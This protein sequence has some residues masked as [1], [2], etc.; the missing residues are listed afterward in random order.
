M[1]KNIHDFV[2][3]CI[4]LSLVHPQSGA[5]IEQW[6][7]EESQDTCLSANVHETIDWQSDIRSH[8]RPFTVA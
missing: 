3:M 4:S 8:A 2:K 1:K 7:D 6:D 5:N